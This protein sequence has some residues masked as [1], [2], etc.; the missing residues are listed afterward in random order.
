MKIGHI[1][2]SEIVTVEMEKGCGG[3]TKPLGP[4]S[5]WVFSHAR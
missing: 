2:Q 4:G 3:A 5:N 1:K